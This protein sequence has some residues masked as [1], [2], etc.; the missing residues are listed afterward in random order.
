MIHRSSLYRERGSF[1]LDRLRVY[2][3]TF[4][5]KCLSVLARQRLRG[6]YTNF[7]GRNQDCLV[8]FYFVVLTLALALPSK[9]VSIHVL[10]S[11]K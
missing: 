7:L 2:R 5:F 11:Q 4:E 3:R 8:V 10:T 9:T 1:E 6:L